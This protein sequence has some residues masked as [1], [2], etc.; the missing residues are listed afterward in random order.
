MFEGFTEASIKA[1]MLAQEEA[2]RLDYNRL[3]S[4][5]I[6]LG[7]LGGGLLK[8]A[9]VL[10][11]F[12]P[13]TLVYKDA[14]A[15]VEMIIGKG[16]VTDFSEPPPFT[17]N[18][19]SLLEGSFEQ[20]KKYGHNYIGEE[21]LFLALLQQS[22]TVALRVLTNLGFSIEQLQEEAVRMLPP[23]TEFNTAPQA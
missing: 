20:S 12:S 8:A 9:L 3:D 16:N 23:P 21:H 14:R 11:K 1:I 2:R 22:D 4:E 6:L 7:L 5:Q 18:A 10:S 15:E 17:A 13:S 19:K